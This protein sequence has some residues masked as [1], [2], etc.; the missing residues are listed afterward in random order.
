LAAFG[1]IILVVLAIAAI[2]YFMRV[3]AASEAEAFQLPASL[4]TGRPVPL[5]LVTEPE[6]APFGTAQHLEESF[7]PVLD[8]QVEPVQRGVRG[9]RASARR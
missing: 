2:W 1:W 3:E 9:R 4:N 7:R 5:D 8:E 6:R